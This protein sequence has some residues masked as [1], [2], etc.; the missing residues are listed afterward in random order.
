MQSASCG[1]HLRI[2]L[3]LT[4]CVCSHSS[5]KTDLGPRNISSRPLFSSPLILADN[6]LDSHSKAVPSPSSSLLNPLFWEL[7]VYSIRVRLSWSQSYLYPHLISTACKYT[8]RGREQALARPHPQHTQ[9]R[10]EFKM[11]SYQVFNS[12]CLRRNEIYYCP[13]C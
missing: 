8:V 4:A 1:P 11:E 13:F 10:S 7:L 9:P 2:L 5:R 12:V 3:L 6:C